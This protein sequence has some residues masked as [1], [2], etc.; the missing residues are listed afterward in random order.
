MEMNEL[1]FAYKIN[2]ENYSAAKTKNILSFFLL[3]NATHPSPTAAVVKYAKH[4][5]A[6]LLLTNEDNG[7]RLHIISRVK[8]FLTVCR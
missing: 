1:H 5:A 8:R 7:E 3:R 4:L 6:H 2:L